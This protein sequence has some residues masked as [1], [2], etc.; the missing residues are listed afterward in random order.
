MEDY[1]KM[2]ILEVERRAKQGDK[3]ALCEMAWRSGESKLM[4]SEHRGNQVE[5]CAWE[6][7]WLE[8]A[9][10]EG[11]IDAKGSYARSLVNRI[12]DEDCR[13]KAFFYFQSLVDDFDADKLVGDDEGWGPIAKLWLGIMLCEGYHTH[14]NAI[15]GAK[16]IKEA[17]DLTEGFNNVGY[18][19]LNKLGS[20]YEG[21]LAQP[22]ERPSIAD[23][24]QAIKYF[25]AAISRFNPEKDDPNNRGFLDLTKQIFENTKARLMLNVETL[26][27]QIDVC[28]TINIDSFKNSLHNENPD[29]SDEEKKKRRDE[30]MKISDAARQRLEA[31]KAAFKRLSERLAREGYILKKKPFEG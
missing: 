28:L 6:D 12:M 8:K 27:S 17:E 26:I 21:G 4:H 15:K 23:F 13:Q 29:L 7:Y 19:L 2:D 14:R 20:L 11:H 10:D 9:A 24:A 3:N 1:E 25:A 30:M 5:E 31:D 16:L 18:K 22:G